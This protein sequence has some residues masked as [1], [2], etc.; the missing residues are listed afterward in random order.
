GGTHKV[1][2][3]KAMWEAGYLTSQIDQEL[4]SEYLSGPSGD[5]E[6]T[7]RVLIGEWAQLNKRGMLKMA[8]M[9]MDG[10]LMWSYMM[11]IGLHVDR[12]IAERNRQEL[13]VQID[14][15]TDKLYQYLP[16]DMPAPAREQFKFTSA[17]HMSAFVFGG[18]LKYKDRVERTDKD[19][20][21]IY[22]K[23]EAPLFK[24]G[25][26]TWVKSK[27]ECTFDEEAGLW[28]DPERRVHQTIYSAGK[29]KGAPKFDKIETDEV[30]TKWGEVLFTLPGLL[31]PR[32]RRA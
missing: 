22:V 30:D 15:L 18:V 28:Y 1:D 11:H 31:R 20:Q 4:L 7:T 5:I 6:N 8:L 26:E 29:N 27:A 13:Q 9:R 21:L 25:E 12:E 14:G 10:M 23:E 3:V 16:A 32:D 2:A 17:Y 19:G 24:A